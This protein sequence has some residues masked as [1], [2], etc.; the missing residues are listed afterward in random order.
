M[1][2]YV[3]S[4][5]QLR[6]H[7][8]LEEI[9]QEVNEYFMAHWPFPSD[10]SRERFL[11]GRFTRCTCM[12]FPDA[13]DDRI[14][15]ACRLLTLLFLVDDIL[16][17]MSFEE[18]TAYNGRLMSIILGD[19]TPDRSVAVEAITFD[20]WE[21][22]RAHD[23]ELAGEI[24][25]PLFI[26]MRSQ[27]DK[28]R[29]QSMTLMQYFDYRDKDIGQALLASLMRFVLEIRLSK[30]EL[31]AVKPADVNM[32]RH[33]LVLN[34]IWSYEK[35]AQTAQNTQQEGGVLCNSVAILSAE[36]DLSAVS[37]KRV[38]LHMCREWEHRHR[39]LLD[40]LLAL[41]GQGRAGVLTAYFRGLEAQM[42]GNEYWS[43]LTTRYTCDES[44]LLLPSLLLT[45]LAAAAITIS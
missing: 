41:Q 33:I 39:F 30:E 12:Y 44:E 25:E 5:F 1:A 16:E 31:A 4:T 2:D 3:K 22:M 13:K 6:C 36:A 42:C 11:G 18:G 9:E 32:G 34:D 8:R 26:F 27:T 35:E 20:L 19:I 10:K 43:K 29:A 38:L 28:V 14:H 7:S 21:S 15:F 24:V 23:A 45:P 40:D 17:T 37:S